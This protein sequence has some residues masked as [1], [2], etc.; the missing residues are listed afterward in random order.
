MNLVVMRVVGWRGAGVFWRV[1]R[2][3]G[4]G[5]FLTTRIGL[6][7]VRAVDLGGVLACSSRVF[8]CREPGRYIG[9]DALITAPARD[10]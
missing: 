2:L 10:V 1:G 7:V 9:L 5:G 3:A 6:A 8:M 4:N